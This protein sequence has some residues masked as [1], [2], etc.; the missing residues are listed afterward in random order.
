[1]HTFSQWAH[2]HNLLLLGVSLIAITGLLPVLRRRSLRMWLLWLGFTGLIAAGLFSLRTSNASV[3]EHAQPAP[4]DSELQQPETAVLYTE[5][6]LK[7]VEAIE[8]FLAEGGKPTL[9]E[10]YSDFGIS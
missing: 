10:I 2:Q 4:A 7:S 5:P 9:V 3:T 1:M 8:H 6:D